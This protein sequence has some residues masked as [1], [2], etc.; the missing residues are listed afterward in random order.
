MALQKRRRDWPSETER[1]EPF[2]R[3]VDSVERKRESQCAEIKRRDTRI[4]ND[5]PI[6]REG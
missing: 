1:D 4:Q 2:T 3:V 6:G 5:I